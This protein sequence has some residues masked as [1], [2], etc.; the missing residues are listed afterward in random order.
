[1]A[2]KVKHKNIHRPRE[3]VISTAAVVHSNKTLHI[4]RNNHSYIFYECLVPS[5]VL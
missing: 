3:I 1:M 4:E 2:Q 5:I